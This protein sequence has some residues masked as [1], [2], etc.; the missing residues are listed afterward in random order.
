MRR[1]LVALAALVAVSLTSGCSLLESATAAPKTPA[2]TATAGSGADPSPTA[3]SGFGSVKDEGDIP[4]PCTLLSKQEVMELTGR[5][6]TQIDEDGGD[7]GDI[8]RFCQWQQSGGQLAVFLSRTTPA[9]F[10]VTVAEAEP[11]E[12]VGEDAFVHSGHLYVLYGTVQ[13]DVYSRGGSDAEN[14]AD[15]KK[16]AK[17]LIP[18]I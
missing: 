15:A 10:E 14:L 16:V 4:D 12:G 8:T 13:I 1:S 2:P 7:P 9:D 11:V 3:E 17:T 6:V 5:E 18:L